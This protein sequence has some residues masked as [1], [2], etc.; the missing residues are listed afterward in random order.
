VVTEKREGK[1]MA[2]RGR[3]EGRPRVSGDRRIRGR[4]AGEAREEGDHGVHAMCVSS[5][6]LCLG[7]RSVREKKRGGVEGVSG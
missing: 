2:A 4:G 7:M 3:K 5:C 6:F 1:E